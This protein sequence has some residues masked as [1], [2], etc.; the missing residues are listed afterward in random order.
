MSVPTRSLLRRHS[1]L[2]AVACG[3]ASLW[4]TSASV[5]R[6]LDDLHQVKIAGRVFLEALQHGLEHFERFFLVLNQRI[7]LAVAA[8]PN[9]LLEVVHA[10]EVIL[11][12]GIEHAEHD[13]ALV[14]PHP[15]G[16]D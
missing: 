1:R 6:A 12:L 5:R 16:T 9:A 7:L 2:R 10:E 14:M 4:T 11:P 13:H 3:F 15:L 8:P